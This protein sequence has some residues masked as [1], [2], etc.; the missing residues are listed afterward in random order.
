MNAKG[1][2]W[3]GHMTVEIQDE[4]VQDT[5]DFFL[6]EFAKKREKKGMISFNSMWEIYG[7]L[8]EE[9][10]EVLRE[11]HKKDAD[12]VCSELID[13]AITAL[14]GVMSIRENDNARTK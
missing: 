9:N 2:V 7:K 10:Y 8:S 3:K 6:K 12:G 14:F 4:T 1:I 13:V 5:L 11:L